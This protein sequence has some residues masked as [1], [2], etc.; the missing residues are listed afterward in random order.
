VSLLGTFRK[1]ASSGFFAVADQSLIAGSNFLLS[2]L[3]ARWLV[4]SEYGAFSLIYTSF[5]LLITMHMS[6]TS[7][8]LLVLGSTRYRHNLRCYTS[9]VSRL[10]W[11]PGLL[12]S[13]VSLG[14][15]MVA[16]ARGSEILGSAALGLALAGPFIL[17]QQFMRRAFYADLRPSRSVWGGLIYLVVMLAALVALVTSNRISAASGFI[18]MGV[19]SMAAVALYSQWLRPAAGEPPVPASDVVNQHWLYGRWSVPTTLL[20]W[21]PGNV[22]YALLPV[23][24][25]LGA[26]AE[27]QAIMN[28]VLP[29]HHAIS[30]VAVLLVPIFGRVLTREGVG[31]LQQAVRQMALLLVSV[32]GV[33]GVLLVMFGP[34]VSSLLYGEGKYVVG[35]SALILPAFLAGGGAL[36]SVFGGA[37]RALNDPRKVFAAYGL[38]FLFSISGGLVLMYRLDVQGALIS[39][40][41][42][43]TLTALS[44]GV[45]LRK[46]SA[47]YRQLEVGAE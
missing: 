28:L 30:A 9:Q 29:V 15:G 40:V 1:H 35:A 43:S 31:G 27:L 18:A 23:W 4:P 39:L 37:L 17:S 41:I 11:V 10:Q 22:Y 2:A 12:I 5:Q 36:T 16:Y 7:E 34:A 45:M 32:A 20:T 6:I 19:A 46:A 3:L 13:V 44:L 24:H 26:T 21:V 38:S 8:P 33:Y 14:I 25:G 47:A 42:S